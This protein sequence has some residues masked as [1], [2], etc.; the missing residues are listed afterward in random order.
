VQPGYLTHILI[1][2]LILAACVWLLSTYVSGALA[3]I[4][5]I[6]GVIYIVAITLDGRRVP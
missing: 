4:V 1:V 5:A 2:L 3:A 6:V